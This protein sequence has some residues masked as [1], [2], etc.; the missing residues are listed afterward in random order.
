MQLTYKGTVISFKGFA[1]SAYEG[2]G[3]TGP[4][5]PAFGRRVLCEGDSWF[6]L[7]AIP[8]SNLLF[9]L[10][11]AQPTLLLNLAT[12]GDTIRRMSSIASN[13]NLA[14]IISDPNFLILIR[15]QL[16]TTGQDGDWLN[17]IHPTPGGYEKLGE[18]VS[19]RLA[20]VPA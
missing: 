16:N 13:P 11:F 18:V 15:A 12:P 8:S 1:P 5:D 10:N 6:S 2:T 7:G 14:K 20:D 4:D 17:E 9:P 19:V 3:T